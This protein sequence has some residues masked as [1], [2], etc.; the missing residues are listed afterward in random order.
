[1]TLVNNGLF[2]FILALPISY[3][4]DRIH[5]AAWI[6]ALVLIQ[7]VG[8]LF[9]VI[10]HINSPSSKIIEEANNVTHLSLFAGKIK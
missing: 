4:G 9:L 2:P 1:M 7:S 3:W 5:R 8:Y 6:G 10:P